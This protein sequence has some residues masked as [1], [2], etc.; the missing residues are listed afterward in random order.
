MQRRITPTMDSIT[1]ELSFEDDLIHNDYDSAEFSTI[2]D[3]Q[4]DEGDMF[5]DDEYEFA[6]VERLDAEKNETEHNADGYHDEI[7]YVD[8]NTQSKKKRKRITMKEYY[9]YKLQVRKDEGLHVRLAG[10]LYQQYVVDAFSY[11]LKKKN[12][13]GTC[14]GVM[15]VVEF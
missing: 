11:D 15:Y 14:L 8:S 3:L 1:K 7:P 2:S 5:W 9:S 13:F 10:R 6:E 4:A 12:Y